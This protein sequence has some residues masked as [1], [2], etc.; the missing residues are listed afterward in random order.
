MQRMPLIN[1]FM[2]KGIVIT[3]FIILGCNSHQNNE[4]LS[5]FMVINKSILNFKITNS[6][7]SSVYVPEN[8]YINKIGKDSMV[9]EAYPK[10]ELINFNQFSIPILKRIEKDDNY[11]GKVDYNK[12]HGK[13]VF[14]RIYL[15]S[16][17]GYFKK[18]LL[19][20]TKSQF[21]EFEENNSKLVLST[22]NDSIR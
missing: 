19:S 2:K 12:V 18:K 3:I 4:V 8:H 13:K 17:E 20:M 1:Y 21:D 6:K 5:E 7:N 10:S 22:L 9:I 16:Y 15:S 11:L 14:V